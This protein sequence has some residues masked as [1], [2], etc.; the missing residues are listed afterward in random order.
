MPGWNSPGFR[1]LPS[2]LANG[3]EGETRT[4]S[5]SITSCSIVAGDGDYHQPL[6]AIEA[7]TRAPDYRSALAQALRA[8][9]AASDALVALA[10]ALEQPQGGHGPP[11]PQQVS[12]LP[13]VHTNGKQ[14]V[15]HG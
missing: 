8:L 4:P 2:S 7:K 11:E 9:A 13:A 1:R 15:H 6:I 10:E 12:T 5:L 14:G 3:G